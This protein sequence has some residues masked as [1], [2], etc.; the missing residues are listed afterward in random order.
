MIIYRHFLIR[1]PRR[2]DLLIASQD[3]SDLRGFLFLA[4]NTGD[5]EINGDCT[6]PPG[7]GSHRDYHSK[8]QHHFFKCNR[9]GVEVSQLWLLRAVYRSMSV[10]E[11][12][13]SRVTPVIDYPP[14]GSCEIAQSPID[15]QPR[16]IF[17]AHTRS[18]PTMRQFKPKKQLTAKEARAAKMNEQDKNLK[19]LIK[20]A[21]KQANL[22]YEYLQKLANKEEEY[23]VNV[24]QRMKSALSNPMTGRFTLQHKS[25]DPRKKGQPLKMLLPDVI[26]GL[27]SSL[28]KCNQ[29][30]GSAIQAHRDKSNREDRKTFVYIMKSENAYKVGIS[31]NP[32]RRLSTVQTGNDDEVVV[33]C[34]SKPMLRY[35][36]RQLEKKIHREFKETNKRGEW[37]KLNSLQ[38]EKLIDMLD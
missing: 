35:E 18:I 6:C 17:C 31:C 22:I 5:P 32:R 14:I 33:F 16:G 11:G 7:Y 36:A 4:A 25:T 37:F 1:R 27:Y 12:A 24:T 38:L 8:G 3:V 15:S 19:R 29:I 23:I 26:D 34:K 10:C 30:S 9:Y 21:S 2:L 13:G 28:K 20:V